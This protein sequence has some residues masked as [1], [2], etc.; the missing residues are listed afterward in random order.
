M[1]AAGCPDRSWT[2]AA[3]GMVGFCRAAILHLTVFY[4]ESSVAIIKAEC[5]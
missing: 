1:I 2:A 5:P 3:F 4:N